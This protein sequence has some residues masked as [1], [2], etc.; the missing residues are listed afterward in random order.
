MNP[1][2]TQIEDQISTTAFN[3][4]IEDK[5]ALLAAVAK[6]G[7]LGLMQ[8]LKVAVEQSP[9]HPL[10]RL[11]ACG[12]A[13]VQYA[14]KHPSN[15]RVMFG[16]FPSDSNKYPSLTEVS[17][18]SFMGLVNIIVEGQTA[19]VIRAGEPRQ[20]AWV[21]WSLVHGLA[22]LLIDGQLPLSKPD[23]IEIFASFVTRKLVEGLGC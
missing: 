10:R 17:Q 18:Q 6:E 7:F 8:A 12:V 13:Y 9:K 11:E 20:I 19:G 16:T 15:Y 3:F 22:M 1:Q 5:E 14:S 21:A 2:I 4:Q 23:D